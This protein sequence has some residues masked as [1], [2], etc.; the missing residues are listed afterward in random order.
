MAGSYSHVTPAL[1]GD[2]GGRKYRGDWS[3]IENMRDA[4][5]CIEEL[6]WLALHFAA[7]M[8]RINSDTPTLDTLDKIIRAELEEGFY[9]MARGERQKDAIFEAVRCAMENRSSDVA[10]LDFSLDFTAPMDLDTETVA[11]I[12]REK[13]EQA[14]RE[15]VERIA[16][17]VRAE[18]A[19]YDVVNGR[20]ERIHE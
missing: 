9:P 7:M 11:R 1:H 15:V 14:E 17:I 16:A 6:L 5:G 13:A 4:H 18:I 10:T 12:T 20:L 8:A 2:D 19:K 3:M